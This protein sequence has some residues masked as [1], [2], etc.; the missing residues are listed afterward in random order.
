[1]LKLD[2]HA[3][4]ASKALNSK[5]RGC[6]LQYLPDKFEV[7]FFIVGIILTVPLAILFKKLK[8]QLLDD[9]P[10]DKVP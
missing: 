5:K 1:V 4:L 9:D 7:I 10:K 6:H 8:K 2:F 3:N